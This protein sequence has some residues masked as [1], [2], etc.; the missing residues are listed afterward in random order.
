MCNLNAF[1]KKE[2]RC[3]LFYLQ[4]YFSH[5]V[6]TN[7]KIF[8]CHFV[9][10][11]YSFLAHYIMLAGSRYRRLGDAAFIQN[12]SDRKWSRQN[13]TKEFGLHPSRCDTFKYMNVFYSIGIIR[14]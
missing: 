5:F 4:K 2:T 6:Q 8:F 3:E 7:M 12:V 14:H 11:H 13:V 1:L 9:T 10:K